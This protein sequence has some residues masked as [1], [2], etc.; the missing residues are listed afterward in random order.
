[1]KRDGHRSDHGESP[2][3]QVED[4]QDVGGTAQIHS[5]PIKR[6]TRHRGG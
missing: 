2:V 1:M 3:A 5:V 6:R 4:E